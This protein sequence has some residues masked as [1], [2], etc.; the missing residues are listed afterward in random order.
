MDYL[1]GERIREIWPQ[2]ILVIDV[3][4][5]C[6]LSLRLEETEDN[7]S[8]TEKIVEEECKDCKKAGKTSSPETKLLNAIFGRRND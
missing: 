3:R 6:G 8:F 2:R 5:S 7:T 4:C 1:T